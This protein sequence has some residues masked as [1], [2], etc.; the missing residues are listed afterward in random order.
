M[1]R[2]ARGFSCTCCQ[3]CKGCGNRIGITV[4]NGICNACSKD[5]TS[6]QTKREIED[7]YIADK[8]GF[9]PYRD[10]KS[11]KEITRIKSS[12]Q[13]NPTISKYEFL[14]ADITPQL[15]AWLSSGT[16]HITPLVFSCIEDWSN[17]VVSSRISRILKQF[18]VSGVFTIR[19][20]PDELSI[21]LF[22]GK[23]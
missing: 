12:F 21:V 4:P 22:W 10:I 18:D 19:E 14:D 8:Y 17:G 23:E 3:P 9:V 5:I 13:V 2:A 15:T 7:R 20:S 11:T 6:K 16:Y 1:D